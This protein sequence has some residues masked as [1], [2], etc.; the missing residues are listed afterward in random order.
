MDNKE[1]GTQW[2][3]GHQGV[4]TLAMRWRPAT[5]S[6]ALALCASVLGAIVGRACSLVR[7]GWEQHQTTHT[8]LEQAR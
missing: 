8:S 4:A 3:H 5:K 6:P 2:A 1:A 7:D